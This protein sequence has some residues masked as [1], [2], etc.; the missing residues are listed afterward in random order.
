MDCRHIFPFLSLG[1]SLDWS[2]PLV[3]LF[4]GVFGSIGAMLL[5]ALAHT[6]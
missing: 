3:Y 2:N 1:I 5:L 6:M 4:V